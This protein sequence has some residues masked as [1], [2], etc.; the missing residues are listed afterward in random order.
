MTF[1]PYLAGPIYVS[2]GLDDRLAFDPSS[3]LFCFVDS[4]DSSGVQLIVETTV[5]LTDPHEGPGPFSEVTEV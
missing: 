3:N 4:T 5:A 2:L 1:F